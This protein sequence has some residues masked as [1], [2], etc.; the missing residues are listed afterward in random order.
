M[1]FIEDG[2]SLD[3]ITVDPRRTAT[4]GD[5]LLGAAKELD[6]LELEAVNTAY[7][8]TPEE[9]E[10][11]TLSLPCLHGQSAIEVNQVFSVLGKGTTR[12]S[13]PRSTRISSSF[14]PFCVVMATMV[15][16]PIDVSKPWKRPAGAL[17][18]K[19]DSIQGLPA[20]LQRRLHRIVSK[21]HRE[22]L[23][24]MSSQRHRKRRRILAKAFRVQKTLEE[25]DSFADVDIG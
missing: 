9:V 19:A 13:W 8:L 2:F 4:L 17:N 14:P 3:H 24:Q 6:A 18:M 5:I 20:A 23:L 25:P 22:T 10:D 21:W 11:V 12:K 15:I 16:R 1:N 7:P